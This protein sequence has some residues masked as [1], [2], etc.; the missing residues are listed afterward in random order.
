MIDTNLEYLESELREVVNLFDGADVIKI[1]HRFSE[2][3]T[4]FV[5]TITLD[6]KVYAYGNLVKNINGE[7]ERKRLVKRYAKL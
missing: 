6:G 4:K 7:I 1:R 3:D 5:N 2:N